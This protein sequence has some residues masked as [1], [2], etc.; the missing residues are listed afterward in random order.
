MFYRFAVGASARSIASV[1]RLG[2]ADLSQAYLFA[3][4]LEATDLSA[5]KGLEQAQ[6]GLACGDAKTKLPA[7]LSPP[8]SWPC[9][10]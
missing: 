5:V 4:R 7:A 2:G 8:A 6:I 9:T 10:D 3:T 1:T